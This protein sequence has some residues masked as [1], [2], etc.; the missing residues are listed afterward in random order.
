M[1]QPSSGDRPAD[2]LR[3]SGFLVAGVVALVIVAMAFVV[4]T[5]FAFTVFPSA[6]RAPSIRKGLVQH[7][8]VGKKFSELSL[9]PLLGVD[10]PA[11][12]DDLAGNVVLLDFW[13]TWCPHCCL[14]MPD[15]VAVGEEFQDRP[16][17]KLV[18][19]ACASPSES[20]QDD[21]EQLRDDVQAY[22][23]RSRLSLTMYADPK[24][25]SRAGLDQR[26]AFRGYPAKILLDRQ[27]V[28]RAVSSG[29]DPGDLRGIRRLIVSLLDEPA[30]T[31]GA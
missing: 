29:A 22:L 3:G 23:K 25:V 26:G 20:G 30:A 19:V 18:A 24:R 1:S 12:V 28:I 31:P 16:D 4:V 2:R 5:L 13:G 9:T 10:K 11:T 27:G 14:E 21:V 8:A 15:V 17:F 6:M 7:P